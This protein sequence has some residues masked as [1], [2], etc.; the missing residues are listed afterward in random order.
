ME[1]D[2]M[3]TLSTG[4]ITEESAIL[5]DRLADG[6]TDNGP[7]TY[8]KKDYGWFVHIYDILEEFDIPEDLKKVIEFARRHNCSWLCLDCNGNRV[9]FLPVYDW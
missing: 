1:I 5:L 3:L 4:H 7:I 8:K 2:K 6:I 9:D